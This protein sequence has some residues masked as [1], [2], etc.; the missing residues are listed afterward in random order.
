MMINVSVFID[1]QKRIADQV[2]R[3][4]RDMQREIRNYYL[5]GK[6][7]L[8]YSS[9][10]FIKDVYEEY[11]SK[12]GFTWD[13]IQEALWEG[14]API[15]VRYVNGGNAAKNLNYDENEEHGLRIIAVGGYSLSRGLTLEGLSNSYFYR[16]TRMYDTLMQMGRWFGYRENYADL[17][18]VWINEIAVDWY[19]YISEASSELKREVRRMQAEQ[20]TPADFGLCV[21]SDEATLMVTARN[22]MKTATDYT[23]TV[24]LNGKIIETPFISTI[25]KIQKDNLEATVTLLE[26]LLRNGYKPDLNNKKYALSDKPQ[27]LSIPKS[28]V[29]DYLNRYQSHTMN[30]HFKTKELVDMITTTEDTSLDKWD[31]VVATGTG[32]KVFNFG[33]YYVQCVQRSFGIR[34]DENAFQMSGSKSRLG[35]RAYAKGGLTKEQAKKVEDGENALQLRLRGETRPLNQDVFFKPDYFD[36]PRNPLLVIYPVELKAATMKDDNSNAEIVIKQEATAKNIK[37]PLIGISVGIPSIPGKE[38]KQYQYKINL[39]KY[40]ELV[41]MNEPD[42]TDETI[43]D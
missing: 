37:Y 25:E 2:N 40:R 42:E 7:A 12:C 30:S 6:M 14:V 38:S 11:Y 9:F 5:M 19:S 8:Q 26:D 3:Y 13:Q 1:V 33:D 18:Q 39:I 4:V 35:N 23:L 43:E 41:G 24:S 31:V 34:D 21:R 27:F 17:C 20:R 10:A 16:N 22:K 32:N 15:V 36:E 28:F 29:L